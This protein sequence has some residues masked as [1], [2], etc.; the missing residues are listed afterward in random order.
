VNSAASDLASFVECTSE[1]C[2]ACA[3]ADKS[4]C[5]TCADGYDNVAGSCLSE[6]VLMYLEFEHTAADDY[7]VVGNNLS[8]VVPVVG[9]LRRI[10]QRD[11]QG[12]A[13]AAGQPARDSGH[14]RHQ[15]AGPVHGRRPV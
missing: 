8:A 5:L 7:F 11:P 14:E 13:R 4:T 10:P 12:G 2:D 15:G 3:D 6:E 1:N 9:G